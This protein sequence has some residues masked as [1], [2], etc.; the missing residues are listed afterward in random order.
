MTETA[1]NMAARPTVPTPMLATM[2][3]AIARADHA[4]FENDPERYHKMAVAALRC[5]A[6]PTNLMVDAALAA[7]SFDAAW[8]VNSNA[9]F[10]KAVKAMVK[11]AMLG[12]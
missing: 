5:L 9:D 4:K 2:A 10:R 3:D 7:V 8:A 1:T 11:E 12:G 6:R